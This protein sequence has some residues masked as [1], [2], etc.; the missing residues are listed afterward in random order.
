MND[1]EQNPLI[2]KI[3]TALGENEPI[4]WV[5]GRVLQALAAR[6]E[7]HHLLNCLAGNNPY[8]LRARNAWISEFR[9]VLTDPEMAPTK[10][11]AEL[12]NSPG[13]RIDDFMAEVCSVVQLSRS[14]YSDF[15]VV[16]ASGD[17]QAVDFLARR[18]G[19]RVRVEVKNLREPQDIIRN[20]AV[21]RWNERRRKFPEKYDFGIAVSHEHIDPLSDAEIN[22]LKTAID[23]FPDIARR[24]YSITLDGG[25]TVTLKR[26]DDSETTEPWNKMQ[27]SNMPRIVIAS[28]ITE[29]HLEFNVTEF[30]NLFIKALRTVAEAT[31]KFF[32]RQSDPQTENVIVIRWT[33]PNGFY[34]D[35]VPS[36]I[37]SAIS[38]AFSAVGL[39]LTVFVFGSDPEPDFKFYK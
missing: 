36:N 13:Q 20:V 14:G 18:A 28:T 22:R 3:L 8:A 31:A 1:T 11:D 4:N 33:A 17:K 30:Q 12:V 34:D 6:G 16:L 35:R 32:G 29:K 38:G 39:Q 23:Q 26:I 37:A 2:P 15:E 5:L 10:A 27:T 21:A 9:G 25:A 7:R 19:K 24:E